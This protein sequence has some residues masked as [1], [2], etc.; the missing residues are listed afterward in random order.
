[1]VKTELLD[2][3][4]DTVVTGLDVPWGLGFLP[5]GQMLISDRGG[6]LYRMDEDKE[7]KEVE[8]VPA[9]GD[10][11]EHLLDALYRLCL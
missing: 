2:L 7:L 8:G 6:K 3:R 9:F 5:E 10:G 1:M 11:H 4:L